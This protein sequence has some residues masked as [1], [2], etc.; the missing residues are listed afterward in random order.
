M[1]IKEVSGEDSEGNKEHVIGN[2]EKGNAYYKAVE[3]LS[4]VGKQN[5]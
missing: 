3:K 2:L 5:L 4:C 1:N